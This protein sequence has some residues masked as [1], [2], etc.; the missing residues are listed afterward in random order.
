MSA[1]FDEGDHCDDDAGHVLSIG[2][3]V[4][5]RRGVPRQ[6]AAQGNTFW[7]TLRWSLQGAALGGD[8]NGPSP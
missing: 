6:G 4:P 5:P 7:D 2:D 8:G 3:R 1:T